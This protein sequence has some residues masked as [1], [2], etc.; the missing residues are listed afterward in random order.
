[1]TA[2]HAIQPGEPHA[3]RGSRVGDTRLR[4]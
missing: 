4:D 2:A 3:A 1:V